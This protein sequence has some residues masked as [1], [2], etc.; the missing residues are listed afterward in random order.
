MKNPRENN[1][2][3]IYLIVFLSIV[4]LYIVSETFKSFLSGVIMLFTS[5]SIESIVGYLNSYDIIKPLVSISSE[6]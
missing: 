6:R 1:K 2:K 4:A 3:N 5:K